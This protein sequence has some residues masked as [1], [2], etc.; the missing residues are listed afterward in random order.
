MRPM[1]PSA[2]SETELFSAELMETSPWLRD[3][4]EQAN[5]YVNVGIHPL[6]AISIAVGAPI[7]ARF[8]WGLAS[9]EIQK[10]IARVDIDKER[11]LMDLEEERLERIQRWREAGLD[12]DPERFFRN[13]G[14]SAQK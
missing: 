11:Q 7:L 12:V 4:S 3:L 6:L 13:P 2:T 5:A 1:Q 8:I 9:V 14:G 10:K